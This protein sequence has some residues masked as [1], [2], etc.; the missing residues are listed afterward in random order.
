[1]E[2]FHLHAQA[3]HSKKVTCIDILMS[4]VQHGKLRTYRLG[5]RVQQFQIRRKYC[6]AFQA[7]QLHFNMYFDLPTRNNRFENPLVI[8]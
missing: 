5:M 2:S 1:M 3:M 6:Y 4:Y 8:L 7:V